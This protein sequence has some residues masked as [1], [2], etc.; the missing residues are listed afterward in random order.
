[1]SARPVSSE[2]NPYFHRYIKLVPEDNIREVL[3]NQ[4]YDTVKLLAGLS[5]T[6]SLYRYDSD[7]WTIK[8]V[9]GHISDTERVMAYRLLC[10]SR[11]DTSVLPG[12]DQDIW[13]RET[14]FNR[15]PFDQILSDFRIVR[16]ATLSL[17]R[18]LSEDA[19]S[20]SSVVGKHS[21][22]AL[23]LAYIIAGHELHHRTI[24]QERYL[25]HIS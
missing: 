8:E 11:G 12:F 1:M 3:V 21:T 20:R 19:W 14:D 18:T 13:V 6:A 5:E 2:Y 25:S 24:L 7:K 17:T 10:A 22:S 23:A 16:D 9:V 15:I 4:H